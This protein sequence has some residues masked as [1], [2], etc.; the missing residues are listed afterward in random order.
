MGKKNKSQRNRGGLGEDFEDAYSYDV[1]DSY[2]DD[3][4]SFKKSKKK[5]KRSLRS[6][7]DSYVE[8]YDSYDD[9]S[10]EDDSESRDDAETSVRF[11][12]SRYGGPELESSSQKSRKIRPVDRSAGSVAS[13]NFLDFGSDKELFQELKTSLKELRKEWKSANYRLGWLGRRVPSD[14]RRLELMD[15]IEV[16]ERILKTLL[17]RLDYE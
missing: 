9:D 7:Y 2:D 16:L 14:E 17:E 15:R 10:Y 3:Y 4:S 13:E 8:D 5:K 1:D 6:K 11:G 12:E